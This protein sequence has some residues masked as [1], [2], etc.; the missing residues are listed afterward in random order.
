[1][2]K[3][4]VTAFNEV[5]CRPKYTDR[6]Q[7]LKDNLITMTLRG[8]FIFFSVVALVYATMMQNSDNYVSILDGV[9]NLVP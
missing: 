8:A 3:I 2:C 4:T 9:I 5:I 7:I 1:M 6:K